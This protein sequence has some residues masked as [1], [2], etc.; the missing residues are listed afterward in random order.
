MKRCMMLFLCIWAV[1][2][3]AK[4]AYFALTDGFTLANI[5][6]DHPDNARLEIF[7]LAFEQEKQVKDALSQQFTYLAKGNHSYV[8]ESQDGQ[9]VIKFL[10][11]QKYRHHPLISWLPL[12]A[13]LNDYLQKRTAHKEAKR[14][15]LLK[16]WKI[17]FTQLKEESQLIYVHLNRDKPLNMM[18]KVYNKCGIPYQI[19]LS[20]HVFMLQRKVEMLKPTMD[21]LLSIDNLPA[22]KKLLDGMLEMYQ[23]E[24][25]LGLY[26]EDRYI[27]RNTGVV[28]AMPMHLDVDR[29][30]EDPAI[31]QN[32]PWQMQQLLWKTELLGR[33]LNEYSPELADHLSARLASLN[34]SNH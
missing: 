34:E 25:Q 19:D 29:F 33:W 5:S 14:D 4:T 20:Q 23:K 2:W 10:Q 18:L 28:G 26:E 7:P 9:Y 22:A 32:R 6:S 16:S 3:G 13:S 21:H 17:A 31:S 24:Y 12:P 15:L 27:L 30:R 8:F 11:F 1:A